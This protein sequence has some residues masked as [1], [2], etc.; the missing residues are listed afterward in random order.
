[1]VLWEMLASAWDGY[2]PLVLTE[3]GERPG[4]KDPVLCSS[5]GTLLTASFV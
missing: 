5:V 1:M 2:L 3:A 4:M